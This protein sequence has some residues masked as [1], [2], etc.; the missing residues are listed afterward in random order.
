MVPMTCKNTDK[1]IANEKKQHIEIITCSD[2]RDVSQEC[3]VGLTSESQ[4]MNR[5]KNKN[6]ISSEKTQ[7]TH[8]TKFNT[9]LHGKNL[10]STRNGRN[11][12][13]LEKVIH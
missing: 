11:S 5:K 6:H 12:L 8:P 13:S 2:Q 10:Q 7:K 3:K 4:L 1:N 9:S